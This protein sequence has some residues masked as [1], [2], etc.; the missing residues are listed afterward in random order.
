MPLAEAMAGSVLEEVETY[1][2]LHQNTID[3][4]I[5]TYTILDLNN[6]VITI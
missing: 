6:W 1:F 2:L 4:Y 5:A 3:Q